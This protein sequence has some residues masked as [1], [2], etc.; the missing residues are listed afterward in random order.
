MGKTSKKRRGKGTRHRGGTHHQNPATLAKRAAV[1]HPSVAT[2][3]HGSL[4]ARDDKLAV[5][6]DEP[7]HN[8]LDVTIVSVT[9]T[10]VATGPNFGGYGSLRA[11]DSKLTVPCDELIDE[12][13]LDV[14]APSVTAPFVNTITSATNTPIIT[15]SAIPWYRNAT[16]ATSPPVASLADHLFSHVIPSTKTM[17]PRVPSITSVAEYLFGCSSTATTNHID[18]QETRLLLLPDDSRMGATHRTCNSPPHSLPM[19]IDSTMKVCSTPHS[20][21]SPLPPIGMHTPQPH[22]P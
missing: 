10:S 1:K 17:Y 12:P 6:C 2:G 3:G 21:R 4:R 9:P 14:T 13:I 8:P 22:D 16:T 15:A 11:R 18:T 19:N 7:I 20:P 5:L